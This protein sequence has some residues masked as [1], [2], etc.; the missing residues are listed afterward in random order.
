[1]NA[2]KRQSHLLCIWLLLISL[3]AFNVCGCAG[4]Q[5]TGEVAEVGTQE[6]ELID[7][8]GVAN[9]Y[10]VAGYRDIYNAK[11]QS[12]VVSPAVEE[13]S[14]TTDSP[15]SKYGKLPGEEVSPGDI[16]V[17]GDTI[18]LDENY[19][20]LAEDIA[21]KVEDYEDEMSYLQEDL[22][23]AKQEEYKAAEP[24]MESLSGAPEEDEPGYDM[25]AKFS[26]P[27]EGGYKAAVL[28]R[29]KIEQSIKE[30]EELF[31][32]EQ[33]YDSGRLAR[34]AEKIGE[35]Q[36]KSNTDGTVVAINAYTSGDYIQKHT[37]VI[38]VGDMSKKVLRVEYVSKSAY[39]KAQDVYAIV[40]GKRYEVVY[41]VM[42]KEEYVRLKKVNDTVYSTFYLEDP[43]DEVPMGKFATLVMVEASGKNTLAVMSEGVHREG[44]EYYCYLFD[45]TNSTMQSVT[46][47]ITD[48]K[49]TEILSG[50]EE[51]DK[52]LIEEPVNGKD[53]MHA[54]KTGSIAS[55]Y[56]GSGML[57][58]PSTEW[59]LNPAKIGTFYIKEICVEQYEQVEAGQALAKI[60]VF[61]D[62]IDINRVQ[63][64]IQRHQERLNRLLEKKSKI[65]SGEIDRSLE[66]AI[67][68]RQKAIEDL[69]EELAELTE[70]SGEVTLT[71]PY[72]GII[73]NVMEL[74]TG[75]LISYNQK[76]VQIA[77]QSLC[78]VIVQDQ[79]GQL[80]YGNEATITYVGE[81]STK[82]EIIGTVVSV[83]KTTLSKPLQA[84]FALI[85]ISEEDIG[86]I[87]K[88]GS[89]V[90]SGGWNRNRFEVTAPIRTVE[91]VVLI[92]KK[93]VTVYNQNTFVKMKRQ[94][95]SF[96]YVSFIAG[97]SDLENYWVAE[98]LDEGMEVCLE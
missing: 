86:D 45:G 49:Y 47:G 28:N 35:A 96:T 8:V 4:A 80:S 52:V 37:N 32:V 10:D 79:E 38:A 48:G 33:E 60:E 81:G 39:E 95:G 88:Y 72:A 76:L 83:N 46:V 57:Y 59:I 64:K 70:Y 93:A 26:M 30:K 58:Y 98:G 22:Y 34:M 3:V 51:G 89:T 84:G 13:F 66:R 53:K 44:Q 92:P 40:D 23:D 7:P 71:A 85:L 19:E 27:V 36:V 5:E 62:E 90:G 29:E 9:Y 54:L 2:S 94:D 41:E 74:E 21:D 20:Q 1:M 14:Y 25:W 43:G 16:L 24:Y 77:D 63:R 91:N 97:G 56:S 17:Y 75:D 50:L 82:K 65:Y 11:V 73:T 78:Y 31:A 67:E 68:S 69:N 42:E 87:A 6:V 55:E 15:F 18:S 61:T 12:C